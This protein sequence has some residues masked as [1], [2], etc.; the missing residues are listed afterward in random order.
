MKIDIKT[1]N[2]PGC[3]LPM[4][5]TEVNHTSNKLVMISWDCEKCKR[6]FGFFYI[7]DTEELPES[8]VQVRID[9]YER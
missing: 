8:P 5:A 3:G 9:T 1:K 7:Q 4:E 6:G 2:C